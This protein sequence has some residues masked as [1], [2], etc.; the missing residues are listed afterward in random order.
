MTI[1]QHL[2]SPLVAVVGA[3]GG[4]GGSVIKALAESDKPYRVRGFSRDVSKPASEALKKQGVEMVQIPLVEENKK[5]V[6][7]AFTGADFTFLVTNFWEH[8]NVEKE[9]SEGKMLIDAAKA[10]GVRGIVWSG[11]PAVKKISGGKYSNVAHFDGK[12]VVTEYGRQSGV[13]FANVQAVAMYAQNFLT[14]SMMLVKQPDGTNVAAFAWCIRP[15]TVLPII[16][17]KNDYGL[18]VR[19]VIESPVFPDGVQV[20]TTSEDIT[21]GDLVRQL[22]HATGK[23]IT[24]EQITAEKCHSNF[25]ALGVP[26]AIATDIIEGF[27]FFDE[28]GYYGGQPSSG[29]D[30]LGRP[31]RSWAEFVKQADWSKVLA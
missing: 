24:I 12:A 28:F 2:S 8:M 10:A 7:Q 14:N 11:L 20:N 18:Y 13:P 17:I 19:R 26:P 4:Q 27:R 22:S 21:V 16:D 30:G 1:T 23:Q 6:Y 31:T 9:I 29:M 25:T 3:T 15:A 5:E